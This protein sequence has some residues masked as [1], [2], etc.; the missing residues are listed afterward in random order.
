VDIGICNCY[1]GGNNSMGISG[2]L[3]DHH[4]HLHTHHMSFSNVF[5]TRS[6]LL[7]L[8]AVILSAGF[9]DDSKML[10]FDILPSSCLARFFL[11]S[12]SLA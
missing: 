4:A 10:S 3:S 6:A 9:V 8:K 11:S 2:V 5:N 12:Q 7:M 1:S